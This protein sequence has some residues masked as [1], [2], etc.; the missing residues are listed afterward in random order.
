MPSLGHRVIGMQIH[1]FILD[2]LP[3]ALDEEIVAPGSLAVHAELDAVLL[4]LGLP[5][6]S[7]LQTLT[8]LKTKF[9]RG[10]IVVMTSADDEALAVRAVRQGA[11]DYLVKEQ[12]NGSL[13]RRILIH[14]IERRRMEAALAAAKDELEKRVT[15]RTAELAHAEQE[16]RALSNRLFAIQEDER[17]AIARE[18]HDQVGQCLTMIKL[19]LQR[20]LKMSPDEAVPLLNEA[21]QQVTELMG[22]VRNLSL[23]LR[24]SMLDDL[25]LVPALAWL[26]E[27]VSAQS[28]LRI[29]FEHSDLESF[30]A[31]VK[32]GVYRIAQEALTNL[33][34][35]ARASKVK[36]QLRAENS[37]LLLTIEDDGCGFDFST[38]GTGAC[39]GLNGMRE[40]AKLLG[41]QFGLDSVVGGG[42]RIRVELPLTS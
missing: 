19:L 11:A 7:G 31:Q 24:P 27:R 21:S 39:N 34:Q 18:L 23:D 2:T 25:G 37:T 38:L 15:E 14:S 8:R 16:M 26:V 41:G 9:P 17:R 10:P 6:S 40:R 32:T 13:M 4:D 29:T 30:P 22:L 20:G 42:T 5:D 3:Q 35:H 1:V 33:V 36:V 28:G 12:V